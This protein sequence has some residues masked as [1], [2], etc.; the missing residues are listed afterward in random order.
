MIAPFS[1]RRTMPVT[2][3]PLRSLYSLKTLSRSASR[4]RWMITCL[5]VCAAMRPKPARVELHADLVADLGVGV[6]ARARRRA[7][8]CVFGSVT[9]ST[10][11]RNSNSSI[12]PSSSLKR[13]SISRLVAELRACAAWRIASSSASMIILAVDALVLGD[14]VDLALERCQIH[15]GYL[16]TVQRHAQRRPARNR[17]GVNS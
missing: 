13:A 2:I 4:T 5:A 12:S 14:L 3:S 8:I 9:R 11:S 6:V 17:R 10:T 15:G 7:L 16:V 1:K